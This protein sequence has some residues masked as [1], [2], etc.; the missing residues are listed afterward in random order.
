MD[1]KKVYSPVGLPDFR[2]ARPEAYLVENTTY[3]YQTHQ[4]TMIRLT[5]DKGIQF[6][7]PNGVSM[8]YSKARKEYDT[9]KVIFE[10]LI[11]PKLKTGMVYVIKP[12]ET[13]RLYDYFES[14][15]SS[16]IMIYSAI[17]ALCNVAIPEGYTLTK[18]NNKGI[19]EIWDKAAIEKWTPTED[20][21]GKILPEILQIESPKFLPFWENFTK[22]KVIRDQ[23]IHLK[24]SSAQKSDI[25]SSFLETLLHQSISY[26]IKA[27]FDL[28]EYFCQKDQTHR[29]FPMIGNETPTTVH[30]VSDIRE[31]P[32]YSQEMENLTPIPSE[33][34]LAARKEKSRNK[35]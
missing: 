4:A 13:G 16:I 9:A 29:Y 34:V 20:K 5:A 33:A 21:I 15:Q 6:F 32:G 27:G 17:E 24:Q 12:E 3:V 8:F 1:N 26:K 14:V 11:A 35:R 31:I 2:M 7:T 18:K 28:I 25:E 30:F 19:T 23:I 10:S 22:L